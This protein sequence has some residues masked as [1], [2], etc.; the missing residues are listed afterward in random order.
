MG[1]YNPE[2]NLKTESPVLLRQLIECQQHRGPDSHGLWFDE[3]G[4][5]LLGHNRLAIID[6]SNAG[7]QPMTSPSG[8]YTITYNGEIYNYRELCKDLLALGYS[9]KGNS[10]TEILLT[11]IEHWGL[12]RTIN[13]CIGMFAFGLWDRVEKKL[14]LVR[15]RLGI[16]PLY[17]GIINGVLAFASQLKPLQIYFGSLLTLNYEAI[18]LFFKHLYI[19]APYSIY[20]KVKKLEPG[21]IAVLKLDPGTVNQPEITS[22]WDMYIKR[23]WNKNPF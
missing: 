21:T 2:K 4:H 15:D 18:S 5:L 6:C 20:N 22:Y 12:R 17:Y 3:T 8:R 1:F 13:R 14:F 19:P 7:H 9:F 23:I 11:A 16:K 10:D